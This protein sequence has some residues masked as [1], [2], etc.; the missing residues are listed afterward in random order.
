MGVCV[1]QST[2]V[3]IYEKLFRRAIEFEYIEA[4]SVVGR[5][6]ADPNIDF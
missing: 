6:T 1:T 2:K 4:F 3:Q 5:L